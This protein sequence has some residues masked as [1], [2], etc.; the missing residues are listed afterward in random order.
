MKTVVWGA[1]PPVNLTAF[2]VSLVIAL[3]FSQFVGS[4]FRKWLEKRIRLHDER[5]MI[6]KN[7]GVSRREIKEWRHGA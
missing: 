6:R 2:T 3:V 1:H 5:K 7:Y 4:V